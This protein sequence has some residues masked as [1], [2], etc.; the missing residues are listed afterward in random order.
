MPRILLRLCYLFGAFSLFGSRILLL[1]VLMLHSTK[2]LSTQ[3]RKSTPKKTKITSNGST[4][5]AAT[6]PRAAASFALME[7][8]ASTS[9]QTNPNQKRKPKPKIAIRQMEQNSAFLAMSTR[10]RAFARVLLSTT[11]RR[12]GQIEKV[13]KKFTT[14]PMSGVRCRRNV[15]W[16]NMSMHD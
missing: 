14:K 2:G 15:R 12:S 16:C 4:D 8:M 13:L 1:D 11:E 9:T 6:T 5:I 10:D 3:S 7:A